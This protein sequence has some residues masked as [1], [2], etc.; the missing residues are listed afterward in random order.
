MDRRCGQTWHNT[1]DLVQQYQ[2]P[3]VLIATWN[4]FKEGTD[5]EYGIFTQSAWREDFNPLQPALWNTPSAI[6]EDVSGPT[7]ILRE[8]NPDANYG[9]VETNLIHAN[10]E[11]STFLWVDVTAVDPGAS[12]TV[13]ILDKRTS[14]PKDVLKSIATPG[15]YRIDLAQEMDWH[16]VQ[17]FTINLWIGGESKSVT[18]NRISV[19]SG[20]QSYMPMVQR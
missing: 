3:V 6:W 9:K 12:F 10:V 5:I 13:Q 4:D 16:G 14:I 17:T 1:W 19:Q 2:P 8:N 7:A 15:L 18:F 11:I 20:C